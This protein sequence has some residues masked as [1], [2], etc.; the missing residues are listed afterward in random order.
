MITYYMYL[1]PNHNLY[2]IYTTLVLQSL[3]TVS[4]IGIGY[5]RGKIVLPELR[6]TTLTIPKVLTLILTT[7][8]LSLIHHSPFLML[9]TCATLNGAAAYIQVTYV[10]LLNRFMCTLRNRSLLIFIYIYK[11]LI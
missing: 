11:C 1:C 2:T 4:S 10:S 8:V 6:N 3:S 9:T 7:T 5:F